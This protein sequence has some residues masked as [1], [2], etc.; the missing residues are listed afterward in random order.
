MSNIVEA[1]QLTK[2]YGN[3]TAINNVSFSIEEGKIYGLL[4]RNGAGK[5]TL[6]QMI[7]AQIFATRGELKVFGEFP[8]E[9]SRVLS[10]LC[11]IRDSQKYP[12]NFRVIDVLDLCASLFPHWDRE[13]ALALLRISVFR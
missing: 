5:T 6:M 4:G 7:A 2:L 10:Q 9:N 11:F 3:F 12:D 1:H 8:Y 13:Y